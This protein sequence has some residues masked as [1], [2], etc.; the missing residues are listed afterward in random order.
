MRACRFLAWTIRAACE[1]AVT[2]VTG[3]L[4]SLLLINWIVGGFDLRSLSFVLSIWARHALGY[5]SWVQMGKLCI[6]AG[7]G[8]EFAK[9]YGMQG[10]SHAG[11]SRLLVELS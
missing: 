9:R 7:S 6:M 2:A 5:R 3:L 1:R 4:L 11:S 10:K 8:E